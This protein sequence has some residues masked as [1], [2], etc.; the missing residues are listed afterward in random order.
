MMEEKPL[1]ME[2]DGDD[3][4]KKELETLWERKRCF[5]PASFPLVRMLAVTHS[6]TRGKNNRRKALFRINNSNYE[7]HLW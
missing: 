2:I 7:L 6:L 3:G 5:I 4:K 1:K